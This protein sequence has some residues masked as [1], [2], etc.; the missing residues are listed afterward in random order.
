MNKVFSSAPF[1]IFDS[2]MCNVFRLLKSQCLP[3]PCISRNLLD[4]LALWEFV[5]PQFGGTGAGRGLT[6][7]VA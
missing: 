5:W 1:H 4:V 2:E 6:R 7:E 3:I